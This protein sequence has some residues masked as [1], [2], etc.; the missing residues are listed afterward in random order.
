MLIVFL[1]FGCT[2][3]SLNLRSLKEGIAYPVSEIKFRDSSSNYTGYSFDLNI[4][5]PQDSNRQITNFVPWK[6][7][8]SSTTSSYL[9]KVVV[10]GKQH[11]ILGLS[12]GDLTRLKEEIRAWKEATAMPDHS[13]LDQ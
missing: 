4:A 11:F 7:E 9:E 10:G 13:I 5:G 6:I 1:V 8:E 12:A 2:S 3:N